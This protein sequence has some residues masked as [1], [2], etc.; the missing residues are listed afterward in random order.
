[1]LVRKCLEE[2]DDL[3]LTKFFNLTLK[4]DFFEHLGFRREDVST[5]AAQSVG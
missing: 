4:P 1:M 3:G 2:A 5:A